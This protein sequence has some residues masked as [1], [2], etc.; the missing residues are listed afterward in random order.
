MEV[1]VKCTACKATGIYHGFMEP[2]GVAVICYTCSGKGYEIKEIFDKPETD[3]N[4]KFVQ[5]NDKKYKYPDD[6]KKLI[7]DNT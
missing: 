5:Y 6:F 4:I 7:K 1:K 2:K 3:P